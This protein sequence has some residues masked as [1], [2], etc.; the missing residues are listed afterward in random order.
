M[1]FFVVIEYYIQSTKKYCG[2]KSVRVPT[3]SSQSS[4]KKLSIKIQI[5]FN[6]QNAIEYKEKFEL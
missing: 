4:K 5:I 3:H 6:I 2:R 1:Y